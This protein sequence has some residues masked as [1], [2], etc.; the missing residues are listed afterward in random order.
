MTS[1][2]SPD[3][4]KKFISESSVEQFKTALPHFSFAALTECFVLLRT[5][6]VLDSKGKFNCLFQFVDS[7]TTLENLGKHFSV[8]HFLS[9]LEFLD[10]HPSYHNRLTFNLVGLDPLV[11]SQALHLLQYHHLAYLKNESLLEPL[12]YHLMQFAHEGESLQQQTEQKVQQFIQNLSSTKP[13]E[14]TEDSLN[15]LI[16]QIDSLRNQLLDYLE[17]IST[18][19]AIVWHTD[20]I[21]LIEKLSSINEALQHQ[22]A[23]PIGHRPSDHLSSTG[24]YYELEQALS[25]IFDASLKDEDAALEGLTRLSIWHLKDYWELGL[26]PSIHHI[27]ELDLDPKRYNEEERLAHHQRLLSLVQQ[28]LE[29]LQIGTVGSLKKAYLFSKPLL[30]RYISQHQH[31]LSDVQQ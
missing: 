30:K 9:F 22:L 4:L 18:A 29:R 16:N 10:H 7:P 15:T 20:R 17:R 6:P 3:G 24:L 14:L 21:D 26:L 28:K 25:S 12:Q 2:E 11:F 13:E 23:Y 5:Q 19:L 27:Q 31:L 8:P 1:F